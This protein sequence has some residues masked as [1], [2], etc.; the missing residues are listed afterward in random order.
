[1]VMRNNPTPTVSEQNASSLEKRN[2]TAA[3]EQGSDMN[4]QNLTI[5]LSAI[6]ALGV[7]GL[8]VSGAERS[9]TEAAS[10]QLAGIPVPTFATSTLTPDHFRTLHAAVAPKAKTERW[11]EVPWQTDLLTA[12]AKAAREG[13][14][15]LMWIMDGH[16]LG[17]T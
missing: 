10:C 16:P 2:S 4:W 6:A 3:T 8:A 13:K 5:G 15:L 7:T 11:T 14:P 12:R 17:C 9:S 1:M